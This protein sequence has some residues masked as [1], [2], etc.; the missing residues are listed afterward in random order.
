MSDKLTDLSCAVVSKAFYQF[1]HRDGERQPGDW[2]RYSP[3]RLKFV[4]SRYIDVGYAVRVDSLAKD[5]CLILVV[6]VFDMCWF[7]G[8]CH[9]VG[10]RSLMCACTQFILST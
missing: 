7:L 3:Q 6:A 2:M 5:V 4:S 1:H 9:T 10:F 8:V